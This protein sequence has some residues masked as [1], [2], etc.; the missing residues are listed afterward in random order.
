[1]A[2]HSF[3]NIPEDIYHSAKAAAEGSQCSL[4]QKT[5][6]RFSHS[7]DSEDMR[8]RALHARWVMEALASGPAKRLKARDLDAAFQKGVDRARDRQ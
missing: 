8:T 4:N 3:K 6:H 7:I 5:I 2:N 1:M